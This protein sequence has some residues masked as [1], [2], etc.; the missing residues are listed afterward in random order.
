MSKAI[1]V[2]LLFACIEC[3][4][5]SA[6]K[7]ATDQRKDAWECGM[8]HEDL[9]LMTRDYGESWDAFWDRVDAVKA[10]YK[11]H[12]CKALALELGEQE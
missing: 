4:L 3:V 8:W 2:A 1:T 6:A 10:K 12:G 9:Q 11:Q 5:W 7:P